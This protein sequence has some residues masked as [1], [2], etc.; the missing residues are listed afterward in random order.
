MTEPTEA[1]KIA[2][3]YKKTHTSLHGLPITIENPKGSIRRKRDWEVKM[4]YHYGY[5]KKTEGSD[6]DHIDV[7][8]GP[9]PESEAVFIV[10]Q[11]RAD[12]GKFD[13]HK[14]MLGYRSKDEAVSDY[15]KG[16][17]D[18]KGPQRCGPVT[19]LTI[20]EFK[21]WLKTHDTTKAMRG[22]GHIDKA[23]ALCKSMEQA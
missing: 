5:I 9:H 17:S 22:N 15:Y 14:V 21:E 23:I 18:G 12:T 11:K 7:C 6:G 16:F 20:H 19:R 4:P 3:N 13:E 10:D 2:G 8:I 1:Q